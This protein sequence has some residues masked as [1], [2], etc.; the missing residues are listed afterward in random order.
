MLTVDSLPWNDH[1]LQNRLEV[2]CGKERAEH[3][4][5]AS[6]LAVSLSSNYGHNLWV[7]TESKK[8]R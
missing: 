6:D 7:V 1:N 4:S 2:R 3:E 8:S 5:E